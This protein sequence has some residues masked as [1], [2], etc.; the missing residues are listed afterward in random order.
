MND[1]QIDANIVLRL[2]TGDPPQEAESVYNLFSR[3]AKNE[4]KLHLDAWTLAE[5]VFTLERTYKVGRKDIASELLEFIAM[6]GLVV[7]NS[8]HVT[9]ALGVY[10][11][12]NISF[13]DCWLG[14]VMHQAGRRIIVSFD[15]D[16]DRLDWV[17]RV[18]PEDVG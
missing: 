17:K 8:E 13:G 18:E 15:R 14:V 11:E 6:P 12:R 2:L 16:F 5:I 3:A 7:S 1:V 9:E 10:G 4:I